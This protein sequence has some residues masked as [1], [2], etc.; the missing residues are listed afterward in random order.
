MTFKHFQI[1]YRWR[2]RQ[3]NFLASCI[4]KVDQTLS[5]ATLK[6]EH[7]KIKISTYKCMFYLTHPRSLPAGE[8]CGVRGGE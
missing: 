8:C 3:A 5:H 7:Y 1:S 4:E 2:L 6:V